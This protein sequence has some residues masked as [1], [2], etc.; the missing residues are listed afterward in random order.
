MAKYNERPTEG[1]WAMDRG[2]NKTC[3]W[4]EPKCAKDAVSKSYCAEHYARVYK[5]DSAPKPRHP[6]PD[7][8]QNLP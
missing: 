4:I 1:G 7:P 8:D 5:P 3:Q 2:I 6:N